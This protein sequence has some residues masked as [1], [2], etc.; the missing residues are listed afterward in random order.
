MAT[1]SMTALRLAAIETLAPTA[2]VEGK[3]PFPTIAGNNYFDSRSVSLG[4]L[5]PQSDGAIC[6]GVY[7]DR[8]GGE[9]RGASAPAHPAWI[10]ADL[11]FEMEVAVI[12]RFDDEDAVANPATD[13]AAAARLEFLAS[14]IRF[15]LL[16]RRDPALFRGLLREITETRSDQFRMPEIGVRLAR[17][18]M[19]MSCQIADDRWS[20]TPGELPEP[21]KSLAATLPEG[22]YGRPICVRL[23]EAWAG[24]DAAGPLEGI[25]IGL[26][27]ET[28]ESVPAAALQG[29]V[30]TD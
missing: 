8:M 2:A 14:Q 5:D 27:A 15:A 1:L 20:D 30:E 10:T 23:A 13:E 29:R 16:K 26:G 21:L 4:E 28:P 25:D 6:V 22:S 9:S 19:V 3:I 12:D 18:T 7:C 17:R 11:V 24:Q